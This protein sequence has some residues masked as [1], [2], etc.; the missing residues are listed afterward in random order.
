VH[1]GITV[2]SLSAEVEGT[3]DLRGLF[4]VGDVKAGFSDLK[5]TL[6]VKSPDD[7]EKVRNLAEKVIA[8]CPVV[9]SLLNPTNVTG[10]VSVGRH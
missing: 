10:K 2:T 1:E 4:M 5:Y 6:K 8:H 9:D 3:L 7:E